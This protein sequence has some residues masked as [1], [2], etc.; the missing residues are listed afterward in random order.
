MPPAAAGATP[1]AT[2]PLPGA[3]PVTLGRAA[4]CGA[5]P[6]AFQPPASESPSPQVPLKQWGRLRAE[7][8]PPAAA[9][10]APAAARP[11]HRG[12][13]RAGAYAASPGGLQ[14]LA[15]HLQ[16]T[17]G[18]PEGAGRMWLSHK[19]AYVQRLPAAQGDGA[20]PRPPS[21]A[22]AAP[23]AQSVEG[24][25][26]SPSATPTYPCS[27]RRTFRQSA[28]LQRALQATAIRVRAGRRSP[29]APPGLPAPGRKPATTP[30]GFLP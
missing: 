3:A 18:T 23:P 9:G 6:G 11:P 21:R 2:H 14:P 27:R 7:R 4:S 26:P 1:A 13:R 5:F 30:P 19:Q 20:R 10:A 28:R 8:K 12:P 16:Q 15:P 22:G 24:T 17:L 25:Q 29:G